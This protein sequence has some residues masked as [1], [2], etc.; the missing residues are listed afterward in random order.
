MDSPFLRL[1]RIGREIFHP[2]YGLL[3][4]GE[5]GA[6]GCSGGNYRPSTITGKSGM[7]ARGGAESRDYRNHWSG[8]FS[9][10]GL[11]Q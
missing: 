10:L 4:A 2:G 3:N 1:S 6:S 9:L 11:A 5:S 7:H 8:D